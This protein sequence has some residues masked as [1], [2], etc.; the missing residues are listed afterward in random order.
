[1]PMLEVTKPE[2][3]N[4]SITMRINRSTGYIEKV[5]AVSHYPSTSRINHEY[6]EFEY[7][8]TELQEPQVPYT[9][10]ELWRDIIHIE[11]VLG[12]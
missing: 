1:D 2:Y 8:E 6:I 7:G 12:V 4:T 11:L 10:K 5:Y 3:E 9:T